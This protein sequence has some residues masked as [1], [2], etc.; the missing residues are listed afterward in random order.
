MRQQ[1]AYFLWLHFMH[2][3]LFK[4]HFVIYVLILWLIMEFIFILKLTSPSWFTY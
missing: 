1:G 2:F 4:G 3:V